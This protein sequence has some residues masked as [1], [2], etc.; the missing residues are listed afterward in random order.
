M[1]RIERLFKKIT[2]QQIPKGLGVVKNLTKKIISKMDME[3]NIILLFNR[4]QTTNTYSYE[5][6]Q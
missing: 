4:N 5:I 2:K 1:Y 3:K 6:L